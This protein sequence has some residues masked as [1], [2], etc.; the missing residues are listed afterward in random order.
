[1]AQSRI[2]EALGGFFQL[3]IDSL[4]PFHLTVA[5]VLEAQLVERF[6]YRRRGQALKE[7]IHC[8]IQLAL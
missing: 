4:S 6:E 3:R 7:L 5:F 1:M 2:T 8:Q